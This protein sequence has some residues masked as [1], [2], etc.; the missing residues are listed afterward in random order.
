MNGF[1]QDHSG[2]GGGIAQQQQQQL[3]GG[4]GENNNIT[5]NLL[6]QGGY[7][8]SSLGGTA[9]SS[10]PSID[11]NTLANIIQ[12]VQKQQQQQQ[13]SQN[14][15]GL[16]PSVPHASAAPGNNGGNNT[17][18]G[19]GTGGVDVPT[20]DGGGSGEADGNNGNNTNAHGM[21]EQIA[22][23]TR[24]L[25]NEKARSKVLQDEKKREM[26]G[27]LTGIRD[28]VNTIDGVKDPEA[29]SKFMAGMESMAENGIPNGVYDIMVRASAQN[30]T[31][32][33]TIEALTKGY[34]ELKD[35]YEG[36]GQFATEA[37]RFVDPS[38]SIVTAGSKRR[39]PDG[40]STDS[41]PVGIWDAFGAD[42]AKLGYG[43]QPDLLS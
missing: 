33:K 35:K 6:G 19:G 14:A 28:Y 8:S 24:S 37:S 34:T 10:A 15:V 32:I 26:K 12:Q 3:G 21:M 18:N 23:L 5:N 41:V 25:E 22:K 27:L 1:N 29:K 31:N 13:L 9:S 17:K 36:P 2:G 11:V 7:A 20:T 40:A 4:G 38:V 30:S 39:Q 42:I 16:A 43:N